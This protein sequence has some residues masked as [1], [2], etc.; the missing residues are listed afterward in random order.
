MVRNICQCQ[1][2]V[3]VYIK[4]LCFWITINGNDTRCS[5]GQ[6]SQTHVTASQ[7]FM[8]IHYVATES[9]VIKSL[10]RHCCGKTITEW[11][12]WTLYQ[13]MDSQTLCY[14]YDSYVL[15]GL[16]TLQFKFIWIWVMSSFM[17]ERVVFY[18]AFRFQQT[19]E[20]EV[21]TQYIQVGN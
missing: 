2:P 12:V 6:P 15:K 14:M 13:S 4:N 19:Y 1:S 20:I 9:D 5:P 11:N 10:S 16:S 8:W 18:T 17:T 7:M 21:F 3:Y